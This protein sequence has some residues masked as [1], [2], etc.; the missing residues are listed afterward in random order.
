MRK[1]AGQLFSRNRR[2]AA[3]GLFFLVLAIAGGLI[4][5][6]QTAR[7]STDNAFVE[8]RISPVSAAVEG[9]VIKVLV[10]D[11]QEVE[12]G[13]V[14]VELDPKYYQANLEQAEANVAIAE[15]QL[16]AATEQVSFSSETVSGQ[17][18]QAEA[19]LEAASSAIQTSHQL[20]DQAR[21]ILAA[22]EEALAVAEAELEESQAL[23]RKAKIDYD[24]MRSLLEKKVVSQQEYD[25]AKANHDAFSARVA[26]A[27]RKVLQVS[28]VLEAASSDLK[29]KE[30]GY[31]YSP[32]HLGVK[33][34]K[35]KAVEAEAKLA[36]TRAGERGVKIREAEVELSHARLKAAIGGLK[37]A[38]NQF[39][40]TVIRAPMAGRVTK[41]SV[42]VGQ[43]V[44]PWTAPDSHSLPA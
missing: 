3:V 29:A 20:R 7:V 6:Y 39:N 12:E 25:L 34:S 15:S 43:V 18:A 38:K 33:S 5:K 36:E 26:A 30:I 2:V 19:A 13:Q 28:R 16:K 35:A 44:H 37:Y 32:L 24:R 4:W 41:R 17:V 42:E 8:G 14:L 27:K 10:D 9:S 11:N 40:D 21:S 1:P 31:A 23:E 22:K